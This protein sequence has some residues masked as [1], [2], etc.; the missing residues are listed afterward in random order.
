LLERESTLLHPQIYQFPARV[1][2]SAKGKTPL[3]RRTSKPSQNNPNPQ[4]ANPE[5]KKK[6]R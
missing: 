5:L 1:E 2:I 6:K 4:R 3:R